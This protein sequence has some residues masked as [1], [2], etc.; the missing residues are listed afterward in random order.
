MQEIFLGT[1]LRKKTALK[2]LPKARAPATVE[3]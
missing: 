1:H 2:K 3:Q